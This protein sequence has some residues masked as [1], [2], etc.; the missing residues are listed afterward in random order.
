MHCSYRFQGSSVIIVTRLRAG[1]WGSI[2]GRSIDSS[3]RHRVQTDSE[4]HSA[5]YPIRTGGSFPTN[6]HLVPRLWIRGA[7]LPLPHTSSW[8]SAYLSTGIRLH[9]VMLNEAKVQLYLHLTTTSICDS[10]SI[11]LPLFYT[12]H[13]SLTV[14]HKH[15]RLFSEFWSL[16]RPI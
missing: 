14:V 3:L 8:Y 10:K 12:L 5:S 13:A 6:L 2:L 11:K 1:D 7:I 15:Y 4:A 9:C 16:C